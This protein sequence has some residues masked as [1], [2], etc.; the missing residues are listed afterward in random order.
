[1]VAQHRGVAEGPSRVGRCPPG[2]RRDDGSHSD[3]RVLVSASDIGP[4]SDPLS[5]AAEVLRRGS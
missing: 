5:A 2:H 4:I 1:M 3:G